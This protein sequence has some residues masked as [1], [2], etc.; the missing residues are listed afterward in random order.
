MTPSREF[1]IHQAVLNVIADQYPACTAKGYISHAARSVLQYIDLANYA[2][3][4]QREVV[5]EF[6]RLVSS[7]PLGLPTANRSIT[8]ATPS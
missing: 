7:Y 8:Q 4:F 6:N 1:F 2:R 5:L 3:D